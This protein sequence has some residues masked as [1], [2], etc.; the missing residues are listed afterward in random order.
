MLL[1]K[2]VVQIFRSSAGV[3]VPTVFLPEEVLVFWSGAMK[4]PSGS[5]PN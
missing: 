4:A 1:L 2:P 5:D 3:L